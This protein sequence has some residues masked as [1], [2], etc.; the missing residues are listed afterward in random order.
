MP[1]PETGVIEPSIWQTEVRGYGYQLKQP[2]LREW[3]E[4]NR[5]FYNDE[6]QTFVDG[7]MRD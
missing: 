7:L 1:V 3:W 6:F 2:G 5:E 4:I